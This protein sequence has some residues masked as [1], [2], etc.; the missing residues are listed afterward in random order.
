M[1]KSIIFNLKNNKIKDILY[2]SLKKRLNA[3]RD[4]QQSSERNNTVLYLIELLFNYNNCE[5]KI[6]IKIKYKVKNRNLKL[7]KFI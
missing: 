4:L 2:S 7:D 5:I 1:I 6:V 3:N